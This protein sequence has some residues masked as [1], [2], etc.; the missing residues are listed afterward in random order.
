MIQREIVS[1]P[2][3]VF[4]AVLT[5]GHC[6]TCT[7]CTFVYYLNLVDFFS[8]SL[9]LTLGRCSTFRRLST[10]LS[11][12]YRSDLKRLDLEVRSLAR[13]CTIEKSEN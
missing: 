5:V 9:L 11:D 13:E 2:V 4:S 7:F 10:E 1:E 8:K 12:L 6:S 3:F